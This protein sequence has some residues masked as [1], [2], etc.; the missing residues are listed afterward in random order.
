M[1]LLLCRAIL[2]LFRFSRSHPLNDVFESRIRS[3]RI[4]IRVFPEQIGAVKPAAECTVKPEQ[5]VLL[6][7]QQRVPAR[8]VVHASRLAVSEPNRVT[9]GVDRLNIMTGLME[10]I[11]VTKPILTIV[12]V[13]VL[14]F[15]A[16]VFRVA[17]APIRK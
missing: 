2:G 8:D 3:K 5:S 6:I 15:I 11:G 16:D 17:C 12:I 4:E 9:E 14:I 13:L 1:L 7:I 10:R